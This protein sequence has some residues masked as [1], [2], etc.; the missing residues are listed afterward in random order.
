MRVISLIEHTME[1]WTTTVWTLL[2]P[3]KQQ[4]GEVVA[5]LRRQCD[6]S[7]LILGRE[8]VLV[9]NSFVIDLPPESHRRLTTT[10]TELSRYLAAQVH[11]H[12]A[13]Q[14]YTFAGPVAVSL[15]SA[16]GEAVGRFRI[17][18]HIAPQ[19]RG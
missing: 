8:R 3:P 5:I 7:A 18:G 19:S 12:A 16:G 2:S 13:E 1:R 4:R 9:P 6:D 11:R 14:G 15:R 17:H 10:S